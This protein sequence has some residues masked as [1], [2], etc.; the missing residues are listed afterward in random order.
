MVKIET[1]QGFSADVAGAVCLLIASLAKGLSGIHNT[2]K[3]NGYHGCGRGKKPAQGKL[4]RCKRNGAYMGAHVSR[5]RDHRI[6]NV[7]NICFSF[8]DKYID[9]KGGRTY[10]EKGQPIF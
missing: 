2:H 4:E 7:K 9:R 5:L 3:I 8:I 1:Y 10:G 6:H